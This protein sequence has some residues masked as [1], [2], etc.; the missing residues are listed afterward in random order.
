[1]ARHYLERTEW[2]LERGGF[3]EYFGELL[4]FMWSRF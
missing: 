4:D 3:K 1:M 2:E